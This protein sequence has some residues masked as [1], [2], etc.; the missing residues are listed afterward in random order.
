MSHAPKT[1]S[2][3]SASG[4]NSLMRGTRFSVRFPKRMA[5]ICVRLPIGSASPRL[6]A[7]TPAM[8]VVLTAPSPT[9]STPSFPCA[10]ATSKPF[11][12]SE[13]FLF[14]DTRFGLLLRMFRRAYPTRGRRSCHILRKKGGG[15]LFGRT[16]G[17]VRTRR[18][19]VRYGQES[20]VGR[21]PPFYF[22]GGLK[23]TILLMQA[24]TCKP[25]SL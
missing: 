25:G 1:M 2:L 12:F 18:R 23:G 11:L 10:G 6:T 24:K 17:E 16:E 3:R 20:V 21:A 7:S 22:E 13:P 19:R 5:P 4:T 15:L 9:S 14:A 8:K